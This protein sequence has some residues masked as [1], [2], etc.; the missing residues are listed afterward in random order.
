MLPLILKEMTLKDRKTIWTA[1]HFVNVLVLYA[2]N[3]SR[4]GAKAQRRKGAKRCRVCRD[5]F[6]PLREKFF[7]NF[8]CVA[9]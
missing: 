7:R 1:P 9:Y 6:A 8:H 4:N 5:F 2:R 3:F